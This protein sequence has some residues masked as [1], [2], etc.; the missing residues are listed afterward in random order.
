MSRITL[1]HPFLKQPQAIVHFYDGFVVAKNGVIDMDSS[2]DRNV[3]AAWRRGY[4]L[5]PDGE[6]LDD[7]FK[8]FQYRDRLVKQETALSAESTK[9]SRQK[10]KEVEVE[11]QGSVP[12]G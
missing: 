7:R 5:T 6:R 2:D 10:P 9:T 4:R 12:R 1:V 11:S 3:E 8:L